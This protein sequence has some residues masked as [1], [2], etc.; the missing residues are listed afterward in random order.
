MPAQAPDSQHAEVHQ[1][2]GRRPC[3]QSPVGQ[4]VHQPVLR[5]DKPA[6]V[7]KLVEDAVDLATVSVGSDA[8]GPVLPDDL[9]QPANDFRWASEK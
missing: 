1:Q 5:E 6:R 2:L 9:V 8:A 7:E 3:P 4:H